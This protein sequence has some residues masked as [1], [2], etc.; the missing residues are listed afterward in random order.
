MKPRIGIA[1][2]SIAGGWVTGYLASR[3]W[4]VT[5]ARKTGMFVFALLVVPILGVTKVGNW[6]AFEK[7]EVSNKAMEVNVNPTTP[8]L[9]ALR[10]QVGLTGTKYGCGVAQCGAC[11]VH[12]NGRAVRSCTLP[13]STVEMKP[14]P[15]S[16]GVPSMLYQL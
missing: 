5:R 15:I 9:W 8:L 11:T 10:E 14:L 4:S 2:L 3:G 13:L 16:L 12:V 6:P 7:W 1:V